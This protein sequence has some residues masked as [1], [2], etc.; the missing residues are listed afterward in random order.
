MRLRWFLVVGLALTG[1][2]AAPAS[3]DRVVHSATGGG[4]REFTQVEGK[5]T[6]GFNAKLYAD[7][8]A[9][10]NFEFNGHIPGT[11]HG[12]TKI[13]LDCLSVQGN[14]AWM[15]GFVTQ[16]S[17]P[18]LVGGYVVFRARDNGERRDDPPDRISPL[19]SA[20]PQECRSRPPLPMDPVQGNIQVR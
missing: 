16:S 17:D 10:G 3:A 9:E 18:S 12:R 20:P 2:T 6:F 19:F 11:A 15:S 8:T 13:D 4:S 5:G 7:G 14:E 1:L